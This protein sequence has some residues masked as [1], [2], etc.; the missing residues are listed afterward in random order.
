MPSLNKKDYTDHISAF[1]AEQGKRMTNLSKMSIERLQA[2]IVKHNIPEI[3][4]E[5]VFQAR[6]DKRK[7]QSEARK[8]KKNANIEGT[9]EYKAKKEEEEK[10]RLEKEERD[11]N[12]KLGD[13]IRR[14]IR[15]KIIRDFYKNNTHEERINKWKSYI[16]RNNIMEWNKFQTDYDTAIGII[17][18]DEITKTWTLEFNKFEEGGVNINNGMNVMINSNMLRDKV[19]EPYMRIKIGENEINPFK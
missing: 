8:K 17:G 19:Y 9:E 13:T 10:E 1:F 7:E 16:N 5:A 2:I 15:S 14:I 4:E 3:D 12:D 11:R 18:K 6:G